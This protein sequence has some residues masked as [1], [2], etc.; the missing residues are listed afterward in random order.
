M[1]QLITAQAA[2]AQDWQ[3]TAS[4]AFVPLRVST[5]DP[6]FSASLLAQDLSADFAVARVCSGPVRVDRLQNQVQKDLHDEVLMSIQ[7]Q[8]SGT[9]IQH[10]RAA[11]L[12]PGAAAVYETNHPYTLAQAQDGQDLLVLRASRSSLGISRRSLSDLCA[13][14]IASDVAGLDALKGFAR[15]LLGP[16]RTASPQLDVELGGVGTQLLRLVLRTLLQ[17]EPSGGNSDGTLLATLQAYISTHLGDPDLCIERLAA[18]HYVSVRRVHSVFALIEET[19]A[20]YVRR[21]RI[22]LAAQLIASSVHAQL[23]ISSISRRCGFNDP[24]T[25]TRA[26][27][28]LRG[29]SPSEWAR[30]D[31][32]PRGR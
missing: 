20:A 8:S 16:S 21:Q 23:S 14:T 29:I 22:D 27:T 17:E 2:T 18:D 5:A 30:S 11:T 10:G 12:R 31:R 28:R 26:F 6:R 4:S 24:S 15:G 3:S 32:P 13:R 9:V 1:T 7:L 25:F 19:P